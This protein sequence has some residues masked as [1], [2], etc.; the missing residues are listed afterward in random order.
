MSHLGSPSGPPDANDDHV[1][2]DGNDGRDLL[3]NDNVS[4]DSPN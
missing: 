2:R 3:I 1:E 4:V